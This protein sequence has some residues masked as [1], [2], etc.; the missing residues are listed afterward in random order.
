MKL[1]THEMKAIM[2]NRAIQ[3]CTK[4]ERAQVMAFAFGASYM[5]S[6]EKGTK[7]T[8]NKGALK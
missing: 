6:D 3:H 2:Y 7:Q 1:T 5:A 4:D 8:Y